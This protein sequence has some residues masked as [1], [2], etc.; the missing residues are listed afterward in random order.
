MHLWESSIFLSINWQKHPE[1]PAASYPNFRRSQQ[2]LRLQ[3]RKNFRLLLELLKLWST[4][5]EAN[6]RHLST[7]TANFLPVRGSQKSACHPYRFDMLLQ[8]KKLG[9]IKDSKPQLWIQ[10]DYKNTQLRRCHDR[11][12]RT[13]TLSRPQHRPNSSIAQLLPGLDIGLHCII[14]ILW[15]TRK[16]KNM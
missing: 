3:S 12:A 11:L 2:I 16:T 13:I 10:R 5:T 14:D 6:A 8:R 7:L 9:E 1:Q 4:K 15:F